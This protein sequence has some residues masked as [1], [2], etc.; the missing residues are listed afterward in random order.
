MADL[1]LVPFPDFS[2]KAAAAATL[3][4][5]AAIGFTSL[6]TDLFMTDDVNELGDALVSFMSGA[7]MALHMV[8]QLE[9]DKGNVLTAHRVD[10]G[11]ALTQ[12]GGNQ[13]DRVYIRLLLTGPNRFL[14]KELLAFYAGNKSIPI[15]L[16]SKEVI[17]LKSQIESMKMIVTIDRRSAMIVDIIFKQVRSVESNIISGVSRLTLPSLAERWFPQEKIYAD[18]PGNLGGGSGLT[19]TAF[20]GIAGSGSTGTFT[21]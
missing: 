9:H 3:G 13:D 18:Q 1:I 15:M 16:M 6:A 11:Y 8:Q 19:L 7:G 5:G 10:G 20:G 12:R 4:I 2:N 14:T 17:F 21:G